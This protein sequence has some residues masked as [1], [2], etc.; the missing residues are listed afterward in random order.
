MKTFISTIALLLVLSFG[1]AQ[2]G[3]T[4]TGTTGSSS[5][6]SSFPYLNDFEIGIEW[7]QS[8]GDDFDWSRN[9]GG[10]PSSN[11]LPS[12]HHAQ[13]IFVDSFPPSGTS[14]TA[15]PV[16][17]VDSTPPIKAPEGDESSA[18]AHTTTLPWPDSTEPTF[19]H[20]GTSGT[21]GTST[22]T[23]TVTVVDSTSPTSGA[24]N[25]GVVTSQDSFPPPPKTA[26]LISPR[27]DLSSYSKAQ[28]TFAYSIQGPHSS[29][30]LEMSLDGVNWTAVW[31]K[32]GGSSYASTTASVV[33]PSGRSAA[34]LQLRFLG[35]IGSNLAETG[36]EGDMTID[37][38]S[39]TATSTAGRRLSQE[40]GQATS[41]KA[42]PNP[43]QAQFSVTIPYVENETAQVS[44]FNLRGQ[45]VYMQADVQS[46]DSFRFEPPVGPGIYVVSVKI[47]D[48]QYQTKVIKSK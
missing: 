8:G 13:F 32:L 47:G 36:W 1:L 27:F 6:I 43:F 39:V 37:D 14:T 26:I 29:L 48:S 4:S 7:S 33:L 40:S 28:F 46:G 30:T 19:Q 44:M 31:T 9:S 41:I 15:G 22:H 18:A 17:I 10:T 35:S 20:T 2:T 5:P 23:S 11:T 25:T 3:G 38:L 45:Q 24:T 16:T 34:S 21:S 42:Y 12:N